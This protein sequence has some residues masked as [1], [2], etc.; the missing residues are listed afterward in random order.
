MVKIT[1][2]DKSTKIFDSIYDICN[3]NMF[4]IIGVDSVNQPFYTDENKVL[5]RNTNIKKYTVVPKHIYNLIN[6]HL[7][8]FDYNN[9]TKISPKIDKLSNL[10]YLYLSY[11]KLIELPTEIYNLTRKY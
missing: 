10:Y 5:Q 9:L 7:L 3:E 1:Y 6:L 8:N 2:N 4:D 11:N